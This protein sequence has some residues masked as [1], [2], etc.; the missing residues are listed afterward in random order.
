MAY[1]EFE[2]QLREL[3]EKGR[4]RQ[5]RARSGVDFTSNDYLGLAESD[6]LRQ[7]AT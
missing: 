5:L 4:Y 2:V 3:D 7:A 6:E 1:D